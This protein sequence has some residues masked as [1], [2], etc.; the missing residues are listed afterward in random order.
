VEDT[1]M[2][3]GN[4]IS[5]FYG[6]VDV[7]VAGTKILNIAF[8]TDP[9]TIQVR[10]KNRMKPDRRVSADMNISDN[11]GCGCGVNSRVEFRYSVFICVEGHVSPYQ[12]LKILTGIIVF[13][14]YR[15]ETVL[16]PVNFFIGCWK[17]KF[18]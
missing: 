16:F 10:P 1:S 18:D 9:D 8:F 3:D 15:G 17:G 12:R 11:L 13:Q 7:D 5:N 2:T 6:S 4:A 14:K